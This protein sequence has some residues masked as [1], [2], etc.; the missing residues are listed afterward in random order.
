MIFP[1][2]LTIVTL[3]SVLTVDLKDIEI[4]RA[5]SFRVDGARTRSATMMST[6]GLVILGL[7]TDY[8]WAGG[9]GDL[10]SGGGRVD[11]GMLLITARQFIEDATGIV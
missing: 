8:C 9:C 3:P 4:L 7:Q 10:S 6:A 2:S 11:G 1:S 5:Q